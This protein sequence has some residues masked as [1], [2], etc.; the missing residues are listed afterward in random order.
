MSWTRGRVANFRRSHPP[1]RRR[2]FFFAPRNAAALS[3]P[4]A[5]SF[6]SI[7]WRTV[8]NYSVITQATQADT[9]PQSLKG[10]STMTRVSFKREYDDLYD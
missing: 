4:T 6:V 7:T 9:W 5:E 1:T 8:R 3:A 10:L 2:C